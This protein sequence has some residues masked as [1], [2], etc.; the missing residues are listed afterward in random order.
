MPQ[1]RNAFPSGV[2]IHQ[3][4]F[5][6]TRKKPVASNFL[7]VQPPY[8]SSLVEWWAPKIE[9]GPSK[10]GLIELADA[11]RLKSRRFIRSNGEGIV[12]NIESTS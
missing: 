12:K 3:H 10:L 2:T 4:V 11:S 5:F 6:S 9:E 8:R 1:K 7:P